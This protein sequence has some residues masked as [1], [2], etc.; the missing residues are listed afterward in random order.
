MMSKPPPIPPPVSH[1]DTR[2]DASVR[3]RWMMVPAVLLGLLIAI[4]FLSSLSNRVPF[5]QENGDLAIGSTDSVANIDLD[6]VEVADTSVGANA[7]PQ[8]LVATGTNETETSIAPTE[9]MAPLERGA[10]EGSNRQEAVLWIVDEK[11][12]SI[13]LRA[14]ASGENLVA[15]GLNPFVGT[16]KTAASTVYVIDVSGS[17]QSPDRLPRVLST[18]KRAV[19]LLKPDQRFTVILFDQGFYTDPIGNGLHPANNRNKQAIYDWLDSAPGGG[20]T[21]PLP[22][23]I[24]AIQQKPERI[25]LLSD[26]EF[27]PNSAYSITQANR[28]NA[29]PAKIDCVGL[30]E[31]VETLKEVARL[32]KGI[33]FQAQ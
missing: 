26:G 14:D 22:A 11:P 10:G 19:D 4:F 1:R 29:K 17:M 24:A 13:A 28:S 23:M 7:E 16:G 6:S 21:N 3:L 8:S 5:E 2:F 12:A 27:D 25:V 18:L 20:G 9:P 32:N 15:N 31:E 33:Y 30:M